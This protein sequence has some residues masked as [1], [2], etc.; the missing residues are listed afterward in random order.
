MDLLALGA[1][2]AAA[3]RGLRVPQDLTITGYDDIP[4]AAAAGLTT[5]N[6]PHT[7]KG[8]IAGELYL[9]HRAGDPPRRRILPTHVSVRG[10]SGL[11]HRPGTDPRLA[12]PSP[13]GPPWPRTGAGPSVLYVLEVSS[14]VP[15]AFE[16]PNGKPLEAGFT[17]QPPSSSGLGRCPFK[18]VA[19]V[20]IPLGVHGSRIG[21]GLRESV[22]RPRS[23]VG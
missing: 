19:R 22:P 14:G 18:A 1:L 5:V 6:Q 11:R 17:A 7:D 9:S 15:Y 3:E 13:A 10:S 23:A 4:Q 8:R 12:E 2:R 16:A 21:Y 20:R